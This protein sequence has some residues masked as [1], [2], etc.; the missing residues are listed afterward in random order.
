MAN[1]I[2]RHR[3]LPFCNF[4]KERRSL[5]TKQVAQVSEYAGQQFTFIQLQ[6]LRLQRAADKCSQQSM[7]LR[8]SARKLHTAKRTGNE[9]SFFNKGHHETKTVQRMRNIVALEAQVDGGA[10]SVRDSGQRRRQ[11]RIDGAE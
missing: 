2:L 7:T 1:V 3:A 9:R 11:L 10:R 6:Q 4:S 5:N 8:R